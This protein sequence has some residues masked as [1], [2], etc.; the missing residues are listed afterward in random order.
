MKNVLNISLKIFIIIFVLVGAFLFRALYLTNTLGLTIDE[1]NVCQGLY[2]PFELGAWRGIFQGEPL[3]SSYTLITSFVSVIFKNSAVSLRL[4]SVI[5]GVITCLI[6][7]FL[8]ER[9][10]GI[11]ALILFTLNS[12]LINYS[13]E[14]GMYSL[15]GLF[16]VLNVV[17]LFKIKD[18]NKDYALW[19]LSVLGL[20]LTNIFTLLFSLTEIIFFYLYQRKNK[21]YLKSIII[22]AIL[23]VPYFV[24]I[25]INYKKYFDYYFGINYDYASVFAFVQNFLTPKLIELNLNNFMNYFY[26]LYFDINFY[27]LIFIV[28]PVVIAFYFIFKSFIKHKFNILLFIIGIVYILIRIILQVVIGLDFTTGEYIVVIPIFLIVMSMG[29][30]KNVLSVSLMFIF[31]SVN[32]YY[33][34]IQDNSALKNKRVSVLGVSDIVN[35]TVKDKDLIITWINVEGLNSV[36]DKNVKTVNVYDEYVIENED[37]FNEKISLKKMREK[38]KKDFLRDY[39]L[40]KRYPKYT[41]FKT[42]VLMGFVPSGGHIYMIYPKKYDYDYEKFLDIVSKDYLYYK[43]TYKDLMLMHTIV[44][45]NKMLSDYYEKR[46]EKDNFII[47]I[48]KK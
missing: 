5:F 42:N 29:I 23:L 10:Y 13:Q 3:F 2:N 20:V 4:L 45:L 36:I 15:L 25:F 27:S 7:Y 11:T 41:V 39:F 40:N 37:A 9:I 33:L 24:Y 16:A 1:S 30:E 43:Y 8:K 14:V 35:L 18:S 48:Y 19:I 46:D 12:F 32:L 44:L 28:V 17:S 6:S 38:E 47:N 26:S 22:T 31:L 21:K 34:L